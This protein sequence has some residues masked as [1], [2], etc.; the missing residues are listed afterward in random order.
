MPRG[1]RL[2][3]PGSLHH[4]IIR[5]IERGT[6]VRDDDDRMEFAQSGDALGT[7]RCHDTIYAFALMTNH[8]HI[9]LKSGEEGLTKYMRRLLSGYAQYFNRRHNRA[10][11]L[12]QNRYCFAL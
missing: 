2:N 9:L 6:I 7:Y 4:L 3:A 11:H 10:E 5:G 8:A 1:P 12:F